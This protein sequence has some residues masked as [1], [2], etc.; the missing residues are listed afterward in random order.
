MGRRGTAGQ[1][2]SGRAVRG[3][4]TQSALQGEYRHSAPMSII[5]ATFVNFTGGQFYA[6]ETCAK[7]KVDQVGSGFWDGNVESL[8]WALGSGYGKFGR[9]V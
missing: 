4:T 8:F 7:C 9:Q 3:I 1:W 6:L 5:N 2:P